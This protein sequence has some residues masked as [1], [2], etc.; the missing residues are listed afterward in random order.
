MRKQLHYKPLIDELE[1]AT[2]ATGREVWILQEAP[3]RGLIGRLGG[4]SDVITSKLII[5]PPQSVLRV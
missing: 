3:R 4:V 1:K 5:A 2:Q